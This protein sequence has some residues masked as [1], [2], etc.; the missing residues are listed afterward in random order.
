MGNSSG[1]ILVFDEVDWREKTT[2]KTQI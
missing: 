2:W 1:V